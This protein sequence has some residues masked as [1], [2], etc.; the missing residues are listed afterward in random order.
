METI[1]SFIG[2]A[3]KLIIDVPI[4]GIG[5][6][7]GGFGYRYLLKKNPALLQK[8]VSSVAAEAQTLAQDVTS[9]ASK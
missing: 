2:G 7:I 4:F 5:V 6:L 8:L 3:Y 9:A 1:L